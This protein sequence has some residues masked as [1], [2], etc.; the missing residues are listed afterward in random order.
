MTLIKDPN[1]CHCVLHESESRLA[2]SDFLRP[3]ELHNPW[4]S[5]GQNTGVGGRSLLQGIFPT[6]ELNPGL[7]H[8]RQVFYCLSHQGS[9]RILY[10]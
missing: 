8:C 9:P 6:Q 7:L 4:N 10:C 2:M 5:P 1:V 3:Y